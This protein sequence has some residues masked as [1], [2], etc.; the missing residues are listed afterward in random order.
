MSSTSLLNA[1]NYDSAYIILDFANPVSI[2]EL[3]WVLIALSIHFWIIF[4]TLLGKN[5]VQSLS[6]HF[7]FIS[8]TSVVWLSFILTRLFLQHRSFIVLEYWI[9]LLLTLVLCLQHLELLKQVPHLSIY[10]NNVKKY[11]ILVV[12]LHFLTTIPR[13]IWPLGFESNSVMTTVPFFLPVEHDFIR[14]L[15]RNRLDLQLYLHGHSD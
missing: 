2:I 13:Y 9:G 4:R 6:N 5:S 15:V 14:D 3:S 10:L 7:A 8:A 11:Q 12:L 1:M